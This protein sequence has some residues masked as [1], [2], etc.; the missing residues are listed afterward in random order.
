MHRSTLPIAS[1]NL[2]SEVLIRYARYLQPG[3]D[4]YTGPLHCFTDLVKREGVRGLFK[5]WLPNYC[6]L[7]PQTSITLVMVCCMHAP[8]M[9]R[10]HYQRSV[11]S[12]CRLPLQC[13]GLMVVAVTCRW[14]SC[15]K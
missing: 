13:S 3:G 7:G 4:K 10:S 9:C 2:A 12:T 15:G 1:V 8:S 6:R 14:R 11:C 5:G